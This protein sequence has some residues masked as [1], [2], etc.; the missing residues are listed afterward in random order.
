MLGNLA[1][2]SCGLL[3][4]PK[5][6]GL[7][8]RSPGRS[9]RDLAV[10]IGDDRRPAG[11]RLL[12]DADVERQPAQER[13]VVVAAHLLRAA[14][15]EDVLGV[16]AVR[17]DVDAHV[18]DDADDRDA[19]L[20]EHLEPLARVDQRD[21][22]RRGDDHRAGHRHLLRERQLDVAGAGRHVDDQVVEVAPVGVL[23]QLLERLR[24]HR[25]APHH[26]RVGVDHESRS[27]SPARRTPRMRLERLAVL[28]L[29]PARDAEHHRLR[30]AVDV[31][32]EHADLRAFGGQREREIDR[33]RR[34]A[35]A[36]LA[37]RR[38]RRCSSRPARA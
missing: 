14:L 13:H 31:G 1:E 33:G 32:V 4:R 12:A 6:R 22:L 37:A 36:A 38:P 26:R 24:H 21:V 17:A 8:A 10:G 23:E 16:P 9:A 35:D 2:K 25:P 18:L 3:R 7:A 5:Y 19:D 15:A 29:R 34:L 20:L 11:V 27:T 28:R 30:R